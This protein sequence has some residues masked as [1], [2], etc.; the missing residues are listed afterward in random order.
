MWITSLLGADVMEMLVEAGEVRPPVVNL[1]AIVSDVL[2][3]RLVNVAMPPV[4]LAVSVP[5]SGPAPLARDAV[6]IE[7]L[8]FVTTLP[9]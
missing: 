1:S 3:L 6:T 8:S 7:L 4:T 9:N 2:S 5:W